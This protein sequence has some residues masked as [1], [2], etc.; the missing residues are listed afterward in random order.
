MGGSW[1]ARFTL[2][3]TLFGI[4]LYVM[5]PTFLGEDATDRFKAEIAAAENNEEIGKN[6]EL[7][8]EAAVLPRLA[9]T[10][11]PDW[12]TEHSYYGTAKEDRLEIRYAEEKD[13]GVINAAFA[14]VPGLVAKASERDGEIWV[15]VQETGWKA[16]LP[17]TKINL[18]LDLQGGIDLTLVVEVA[19]AVSS[20]VGRDV[21]S[22]RDSAESMG[23]VI[24]DVRRKRGEPIV[25]VS[26][27]ADASRGEITEAV[28]R[29]GDY[30]AMSSYKEDG[31]TWYPYE[32]SSAAQVEIELRSVDQALE[33]L[34]NRVDVT[35]V[36][37]PSIVK[38]GDGINIQ[39]PG[40]DNLE[41]AIDV[42]GTTA[43]LE[44]F[45]VDEEFDTVEL[46]KGLLAAEEAM[47]TKDYEDDSKLNDWLI[48]EG[49]VE[50]NR[51]VLWQYQVRDDGSDRRDTPYVLKSPAMI[52]GDDINDAFVQWDRLGDP[53][54]SLE[55]KGPGGKKFGQ[56]TGDNVG[57]R[58]AIV[59][60]DKIRSAPVIREKISGG[61]A[62]ISMGS[63]NMNSMQG[64]AQVLSMVLRTGAL[65]APVT[66]A[67][68]RT[69][70][71][72]LGAD[73]V[74]QGVRGTMVGAAL[75]LIF[76]VVYYAKIG[77]VANVALAM[78]VVFIMALLALMGATLTLPGIAGIA[79]TV[80]MAVDAN[81]IIYERIREELRLG[82]TARAAVDA[83][84]EN[85]FSAVLDANITTAIAGVVLYSYGTG[86]IKGFAVTL[87]I[88]IATT[89]FTAVFV[90]R[91]FM[92]FV[93]R[94]STTRLA[95]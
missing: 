19:E 20:S 73:S 58:F 26:A 39:L 86:P 63:G 51:M 33:G 15:S 81:I 31:K 37:E 50:S 87:L 45:L 13:L 5:M 91:T 24:D 36:K 93:V 90:S 83:G 23:V 21:Q 69:V 1:W 11:G 8:L 70:G 79:L 75:V 61:R 3:L 2:I 14:D 95:M 82:K 84:F 22:V 41:Q 54:V 32:L 67:E 65:P 56:V 44:F 12:V 17:D 55:F 34:R 9:K 85:G 62:Q 76:M 68:V 6:I 52:G 46:E 78:N 43:V 66:I 42:I 53:Y 16:Y 47:A 72:Q 25:E 94:K 29:N 10:F 48:D 4:A 74:A 71:A 80:G 30:I 18:G 35:G 88:G 40:M 92:D 57:K 49:I 28:R 27:S 38:K 64:E 60:D 7:A 89:L 59:L 77:L